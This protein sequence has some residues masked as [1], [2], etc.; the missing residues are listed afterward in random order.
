MWQNSIKAAIFS[1]CVAH[2]PPLHPWLLFADVAGGSHHCPQECQVAGVGYLPCLC[3]WLTIHSP[4]RSLLP[5]AFPPGQAIPAAFPAQSSFLFWFARSCYERSKGSWS[6]RLM[7]VSFFLILRT[8]SL[9]AQDSVWKDSR[10]SYRAEL[11]FHL[12]GFRNN[13]LVIRLPGL[14]YQ[15]VLVNQITSANYPGKGNN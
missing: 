15:I 12:Q 8:I 11:K 10:L 4:A 1:E 3:G 5:A 14:L 7:F 9:C 2:L 13:P 6:K